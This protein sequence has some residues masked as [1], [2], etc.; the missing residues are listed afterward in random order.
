MAVVHKTVFVAYSA[1]QMFALV[2]DVEKYPQ[3]LPW[4][5]EVRVVERTDN[6]LV[7]TLAINYHGIKQQFT[8]KNNNQRPHLMQM[9]L[10]E[11]PFRQLSG[12]WKF[13]E[14]RVDACKI[15]FDLNYEFSSK[16]LEHLIG[17]VFSKIANSFVD[18]FCTRAEALY[19]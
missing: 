19:G 16:L 13:T 10:V 15:E 14:L 1:E 11:G 4:C 18:S 5:G 3:F 7:A 6:E 9:N 12:C 2:D 17:P 8:T